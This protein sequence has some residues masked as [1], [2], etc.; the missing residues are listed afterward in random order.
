MFLGMIPTISLASLISWLRTFTLLMRRHWLLTLPISTMNLAW[1][2]GW[3][4][5]PVRSVVTCLL[6]LIWRLIE[7]CYRISIMVHRLIAI[8]LTPSCPQSLS[9]W[10][11]LSGLPLISLTVCANT[12]H[13]KLQSWPCC[14]RC[15]EFWCNQYQPSEC[16]YERRRYAKCA[17]PTLSRNLEWN[18]YTYL[19]Y[20]F[21]PN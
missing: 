21:F 20:F 13:W 18:L 19:N 14:I 2:S 5:L 3:Q 10:T 7:A 6:P 4:N 8:K 1:I 9:G 11:K 16:A 17:W 15:Y 12:S